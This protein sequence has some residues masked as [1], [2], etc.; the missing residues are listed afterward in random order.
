VNAT[1]NT[2]ERER[3][4]RDDGGGGGRIE[5]L[6]VVPDGGELSDADADAV[7]N[8]GRERAVGQFSTRSPIRG[9]GRRW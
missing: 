8:Q 9:Q 3:V 4:E 5:R 1:I 6:E 7:I 2:L